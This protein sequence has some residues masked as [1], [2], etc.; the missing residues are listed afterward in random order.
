VVY[1][2]VVVSVE[3]VC[4]GECNWKCLGVCGVCERECMRCRVEEAKT[5]RP[6]IA[7]PSSTPLHIIIIIIDGGTNL[8]LLYNKR[9]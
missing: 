4:T 2:N 8:K 5:G 1:V 6:T 3:G 7:R 9:K